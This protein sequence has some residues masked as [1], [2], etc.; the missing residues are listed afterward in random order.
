MCDNY[1]L[2]FST[3]NLWCYNFNYEP[4]IDQKTTTVISLHLCSLG[5][6]KK[7]KEFK[8]RQKNQ[9]KITK[10]KRRAQKQNK[11]KQKKKKPTQTKYEYL[12]Y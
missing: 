2:L 5:E 9:N 7:K 1:T 11:T 6:K 12:I 8:T 10:Q 3:A 4:F